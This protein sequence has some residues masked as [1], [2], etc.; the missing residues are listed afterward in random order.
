MDDDD[1]YDG[2]DN[3]A[4]VYSNDDG[5]GADDVNNWW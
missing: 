4:D 2:G 5:H 1:T 3:D